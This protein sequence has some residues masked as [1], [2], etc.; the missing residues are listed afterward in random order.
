MIVIVY[1]MRFNY[2]PLR[3]L[4]DKAG[5]LT[6]LER[7]KDELSDIEDALELLNGRSLHLQKR[8]ESTAT[9]VK[10]A[11]LQTGDE[12]CAEFLHLQPDLLF[13]RV[14]L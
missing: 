14:V 10:S 7:T 5:Q 6:N 8:L 2:F 9:S 1:A 11:R 12:L 3:R 13:H 4:Q